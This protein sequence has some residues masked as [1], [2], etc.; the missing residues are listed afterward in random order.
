MILGSRLLF[1]EIGIRF[2]GVLIRRALFFGVY[3]GTA[4]FGK[5]PYARSH[6]V[7]V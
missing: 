6:P 1:P 7:N 5:L 3:I 2:V 4:D